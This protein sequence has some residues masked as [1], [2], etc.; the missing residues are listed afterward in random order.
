MLNLTQL[1]PLPM[2]FHLVVPSP[3]KLEPPIERVNALPEEITCAVKPPDGQIKAKCPRGA[4]NDCILR[5]AR[6]V[7]VFAEQARPANNELANGSQWD[8]LVGLC[9]FTRTQMELSS[10]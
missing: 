6:V 1:N 7:E 10:A 2:V 3:H 9:G 5:L 8:G 4:L